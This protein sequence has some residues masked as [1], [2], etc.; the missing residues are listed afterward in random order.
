[1]SFKAFA[2]SWK[3]VDSKTSSSNLQQ[4]IIHWCEELG[5]DKSESASVR[6]NINEWIQNQFIIEI[7]ITVVSQLGFIISLRKIFF[8]TFEGRNLDD[9]NSNEFVQYIKDKREFI[10]KPNNSRVVLLIAFVLVSIGFL[11]HTLDRSFQQEEQGWNNSSTNRHSVTSLNQR[12]VLVLVINVDRE[13]LIN[14]LKERNKITEADWEELYN[15]TQFLWVG[16]AS[17]L[18]NSDIFNCFSRSNTVNLD[19][20][21]YDVYFIRIDLSK[22]DPGFQPNVLQI[23]R[24]DAFQRLPEISRDISISPRLSSEAYSG[25]GFYNR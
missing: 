18:E 1:M 14:I 22:P 23:D 21:E 16:T 3:L 9:L 19:T 5:L 6:A 24:R 7:A 11:L 4:A 8:N 25:K 12:N 2:N 17:E 20:S 13:D 10:E 15:A